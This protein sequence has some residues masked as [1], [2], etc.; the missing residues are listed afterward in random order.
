MNKNLDASM[1]CV[2]S[3]FLKLALNAFDEKHRYLK[4]DRK[5]ND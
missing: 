2:S 5:K 4:N 1:M 3:I